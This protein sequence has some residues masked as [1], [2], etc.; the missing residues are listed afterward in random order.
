MRYKITKDVNNP[1]TS[2]K[3]Y[4]LHQNER[5]IWEDEQ[6]QRESRI[7]AVIVAVVSVVAIVAVVLS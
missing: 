2:L 3:M 4:L 5:T 7:L 6:R 1:D